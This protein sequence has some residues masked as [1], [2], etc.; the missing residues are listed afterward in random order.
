MKIDLAETMRLATLATRATDVLKATPRARAPLGEVL[1]ALRAGRFNPSGFAPLRGREPSRSPPA[2][3]GAEFRTLS[4]AC[5]AGARDYNLYIPASARGAPNGLIV[6]LHGCKQDPDDFAIGTRMNAIAESHGLS[7]AYPRQPPAA[8]PSSC[9]NWFDP[10]HQSRDAGEPA[11]IAGLTRDIVSRY[12]LDR[13]RTFVA[14]LSAGG[15]MAVVIGETYPELYGAVGVHSG[16]AY[17]SAKDMASAFAAMRGPVSSSSAR[18]RAAASPPRTI[19][20]HGGVDR[21]VHP[22]NADEIVAAARSGLAPGHTELEQEGLAGDRRYTNTVLLDAKGIPVVELWRIDGSGHAWSGGDPA[23]SFAD[24]K[25]PD[26][27]A[28]MARFFLGS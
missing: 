14:G 15:A 7:V 1:R 16:L 18:R 6:M 24:A 4:F 2:P 22:G 3:E 8:N 11:I 5:A 25:G 9:W 28:E 26:A 19:V 17:Q 23:G 21:T 12:S 13:R 10:A 20:F 27:S